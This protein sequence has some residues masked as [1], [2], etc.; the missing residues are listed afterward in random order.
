MEKE[1][2]RKNARCSFCGKELNGRE[3]AVQ[4]GDGAI[5]C[6]ECSR[7]AQGY[8]AEIEKEFPS[9]GKASAPIKLKKPKEIKR[10]LDEYVIGQEEAKK[11]LSV[12]VYNHYKRLNHVAA[13][14]GEDVTE[15]EKSNIVMVGPTGTGK[16]LLVRSIARLLEVPFCIADATVLTEAGYVGE[17]VDSILSRLL[18]AADF[19]VAQAERGIIFIDE[20]DK[21]AR[22]G[23][24]PSITRDVSGE[25]VQ[26]ALLKLLEG[27]DALVPP[28]GGRKHPNAEMVKI[29]TRHILF[30]GG[31]SFD[32]LE[33]HIASR[34]NRTSIGYK[35]DDQ[36]VA[37]DKDESL[38]KYVS[39]QDLRSFGMIPEL[40][41]RFPVL[42]YLNELD[43]DALRSILV[44]PKNALVR[45]YKQLFA[46]DGVD[47]EFDP[48]VYDF[49]VEKALE[50]NIGARGLRGIMEAMMNELMYELPS[51]EVK[52]YRVTLD[53]VKSHFGKSLSEKLKNS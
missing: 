18:Q 2:K 41:G 29:N 23:S 31:G 17:D 10:F 19:D 24:N 42:A 5:L 22:K 13:H 27:T 35:K 45:Q 28:Q 4:G 47:L 12:A 49:I 15:I 34:M 44:E 6:R 39:P 50:F 9:K 7:I 11:V 30:I 37:A 26:Q 33:R 14:Q 38:L 43:A 36:R 16:T 51:S 25:G 1:K 32:G 48:E 20:I 53:Y 8:F 52:E 3:P 46:M 40:V 21:I